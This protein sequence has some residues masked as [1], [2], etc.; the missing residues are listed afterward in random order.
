MAGYIAKFAERTK[1]GGDTYWG[2]KDLQRRRSTSVGG[3]LG[4]PVRTTLLARAGALADWYTYTPGEPEHYF[5]AYTNWGA[6]VGLQRELRSSEFFTDHHFHYG[7]FTHATGAAR[8]VDPVFL[9]DYGEMADAGGAPVRQ[10]G[11]R[12]RGLPVPA[13]LRHLGRPLLRGRLQ[14]AGR[15][16]PGVHLGGDAVVGRPVPAGAGAGATRP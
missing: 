7:Y 14:L 4:E 1:Y 6:L 2:G 12:Q 10:L 5:A 9:D 16:Q 3:A 13:H 11:P 8:P 15:Q